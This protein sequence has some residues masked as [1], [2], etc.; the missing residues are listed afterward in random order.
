MGRDKILGIVLVSLSVVVAPGL[1]LVLIREGSLPL[2]ILAGPAVI[3]LVGLLFLFTDFLE[4]SLGVKDEIEEMPR[5][6]ED[7]I[8]A[9]FSRRLTPAHLMVAATIVAAIL[10]FAILVWYKK[11]EASWGPVNVL[12]VSAAMVAIT[13]VVGIKNQWFQKRTRRTRWWI[14]LIPLAGLGLSVGLGLYATEPKEFGGRTRNI[15]FLSEPDRWSTSRASQSRFL[16]STIANSLD[17]DIDCDGE[18]CL[19][20]LLALIA[21]VCVV[22]SA[23]IPHF[24]VLAAHWLLTIM[25]LLALR[26]LLFS[27]RVKSA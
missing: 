17:I 14:F 24:W 1:G 22:S 18:E 11:W 15:G 26:E 23:F 2:I 3:F 10:L 20:L 19:V 13:L 9:L 8:E 4:T 12:V 16:G 27:E 6:V 25:V 7:D 21:I 5:L